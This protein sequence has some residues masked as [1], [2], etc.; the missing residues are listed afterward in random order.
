MFHLEVNFMISS[1][2]SIICSSDTVD[3]DNDSD[4][5]ENDIESGPSFNKLSLFI[6][7]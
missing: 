7:Y 1:V 5:D 2:E 4:D 3:D 6:P